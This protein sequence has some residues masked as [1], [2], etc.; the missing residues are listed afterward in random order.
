MT[1]AG[2]AGLRPFHGTGVI[3]VRPYTGP[4]A[5]P[6]REDL[7]RSPV[8]AIAGASPARGTLKLRFG[9]PEAADVR[10]EIYDVG[11]RRVRSL[12][13]ERR[14]AGWYSISWEGKAEG[15]GTA[16]SGIYF[17]HMITGR[18]RLHQRVVW[19]R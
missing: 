19:L 8:L 5:V 18:A 9:L 12:V 3:E 6:A 14:P 17:V 4:T 1:V 13:G 2:S 10:L 16:A 15:G 11:G 7:P